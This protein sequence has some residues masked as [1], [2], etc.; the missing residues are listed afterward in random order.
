MGMR[1]EDPRRIAFARERL[2]VGEVVLAL[3]MAIFDHHSGSLK[4]NFGSS[5][6]TMAVGIAVILSQLA[7]EPI[8]VMLLTKALQI[9]RRR[10]EL[11]LRELSGN[12]VLVKEGGNYV[13]NP[14]LF[15]ETLEDAKH[16]RRLRSIIVGGAKKLEVF[17]SRVHTG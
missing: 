13:A 2:V 17:A 3:L 9:P 7:A 12:G 14:E 4:R 5:L 11:R 8:S 1:K 15:R 16:I 6:E 10:V